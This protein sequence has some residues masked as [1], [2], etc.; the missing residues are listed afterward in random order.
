M[1]ATARI[2]KSLK[3]LYLFIVLVGSTAPC[4]TRRCLAEEFIKMK[5][6]SSPQP[7]ECI[8]TVNLTSIQYQTLSV[9]TKVMQF[10][11]RIRINME[12]KDPDLAWS[13][14]QYMF[15]ELVLPFNK[16]WTPDLGVDNAVYMDVKPVSSDILV[17][18]DGTVSHAI[19]MY[20]TV[21]CGIN[22]F[23]Y[24]FVQGE[25]PVAINGWNQ[26]SC[27]LHLIYGSVFTVGGDRGEWQTISVKLHRDNHA[28]N[29]NYLQVTMSMNPFNA[30]VSLVLP[31]ALIMVADLVSFALPLEGGKRSS[32]KITLVLSFTMFLLILTNSLPSAEH[33]SPLIRYHFCFCMVCLVL[34][35]LVSMLFTKLT[36]DGSIQPFR[37]QEM[38]EPDLSANCAVTKSSGLTKEGDSLDKI[39]IFLEKMDKQ[40]NQ[41][42]KMQIFANNLDKIC[43]WIFLGLD[44]IYS[45]CI[46]TFTRTAYCKFNNLDF[47]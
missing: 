6:F 17:Q 12:W 31:S 27:G 14:S 4:A 28:I 36:T 7:P 30:L 26:S 33:C 22:L 21:V 5:L 37:L 1:M 8:V 16:I 11:S 10:S 34:S 13:D 24:P 2:L 3:I 44:I 42:K 38:S 29:R 35:M 40:E 45:L 20:T 25:C 15:D 23:T 19:L 46:I 9:D 39:V 43:F 18:R 47:W 32:F 41:I